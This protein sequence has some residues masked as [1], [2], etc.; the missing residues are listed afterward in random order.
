M[1]DPD[2]MSVVSDTFGMF[3]SLVVG[4]FFLISLYFKSVMKQKDAEIEN[5][6][7]ELKEF[8][9]VSKSRHLT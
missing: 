6:K 9:E 7:K 8:K 1:P 5:G 4:F 3:E 2:T